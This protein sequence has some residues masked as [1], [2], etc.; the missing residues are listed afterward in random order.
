M[1][2]R[3]MNL[4]FLLSWKAAPALVLIACLAPAHAADKPRTAPATAKSNDRVLTPAQLRECLT[5]KE[6]L[7]GQTDAALKTKGAIDAEK[8]EIDRSAAAIADALATLD[9]T[10]AQEVAAHNAKVEE[11]G[12]LV[13]AYRAKVDAYNG[14]AGT[15]QAAHDS[16][17]K[18]CGNRRY[19]DRDLND[20]QRKK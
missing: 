17:E 14:Q 11:R 7:R 8:A 18:S 16:Y 20:L 9:R 13:D 4:H 15:I 6:Q 19:D 2:S 5:Q 1:I 10:N 3:T 12:A